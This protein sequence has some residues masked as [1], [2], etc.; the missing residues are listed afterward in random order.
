VRDLRGFGIQDVQVDLYRLRMGWIGREVEGR[1]S[2]AYE[3]RTSWIVIIE[4][5]RIREIWYDENERTKKTGFQ[6]SDKVLNLN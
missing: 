4:S 1:W 5:N 3:E 6:E 2:R